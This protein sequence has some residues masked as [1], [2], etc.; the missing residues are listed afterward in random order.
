ML[1]SLYRRR[2]LNERVCV[3]SSFAFARTTPQML[4]LFIPKIS[5]SRPRV[6]TNM[7]WTGEGQWAPVS[8]L[9]TTMVERQRLM[10]HWHAAVHTTAMWTRPCLSKFYWNLMIWISVKCC[11]THVKL[12]VAI[13][14]QYFL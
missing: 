5:I 14:S 3:E 8:T 13:G 2:S 12:Q 6:F 9:C 7:W 10:V 11:R 4:Y 1:P